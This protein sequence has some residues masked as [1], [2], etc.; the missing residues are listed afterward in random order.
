MNRKT[1]LILLVLVLAGFAYFLFLRS[2]QT[3]KPQEEAA[4]PGAATKLFTLTSADVQR[5]SITP[6]GEKPIVLERQDA[7]WQMTSPVSAKADK[8][9]ADSL[10]GDIL[11]LASRGQVDAR[12]ADTGLAQ[13]RYQVELTG[14]DGKTTKLAI[15]SKSALG[16]TMFVQLDG[17]PAAD[18][19]P[20]DL[21]KRLGEPAT[22]LRDAKLIDVASGEIRQIKVTLPESE[23]VL[24]K[25]G[26]DWR[27]TRPESM[28]VESS[29]ASDLTWQLSSLRAADFVSSDP[30]PAPRYQLDEP[31]ATVW[32]SKDAP[33]TQ[34]STQAA[35]SPAGITVKLGRYDGPEKTNLYASV[36]T[37]PGVVKVPAGILS[38]LKK[39]PLQLRDR[40]AFEL[41]P[42][43]V[44]SISIKMDQPATTQPTTREAA[45][46]SLELKRN[47]AP[48][49][50]AGPPAPATTQAAGAAATQPASEPATQEAAPAW[51]FADGKAADEGKVTAL[52]EA[53]RTI[54]ATK[55]L[56][57]ADEVKPQAT[58]IVSLKSIATGG[59]VSQQELRLLDRGESESPVGEA[60]G[61]RFELDRQVLQKLKELSE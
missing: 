54:R 57:P 26:D 36:S 8:Y 24:E 16:D 53:L 42:D 1:N 55:Y 13:P 20:A 18:V 35:T 43:A 50:V 17:K 45:S 29:E 27:M 23:M 44:N 19:T 7:G 59:A 48:V 28:P 58:W 49:I 22:K 30:T 41:S 46:K 52:L 11:D 32:F 9:T 6:E 25:S 4:K 39:T 60:G 38:H 12:K 3:E 34:P 2:P 56:H 37:L 10:V 47:P 51:S 33:A 40:K 5:L 31:Q 15:G 14:K 61:L 21:L